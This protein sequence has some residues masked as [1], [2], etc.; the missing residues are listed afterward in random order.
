M[1]G[2]ESWTIKKAEHQ[3][4]DANK[5]W[6]CRRLLRVPW[7]SRISNQSILKEIKP[8]YSLE[9]L[10]LRVKLQYFGHWMWRP[11][12]CESLKVGVDGLLLVVVESLKDKGWWDGLMASLTQCLYFEQAL[13]DSGLQGSLDCCNPQGHKELN[14]TEQLHKNKA[15]G[16]QDHRKIKFKYQRI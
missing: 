5:L 2:C 7:T 8:E 10:M 3:R 14:P 4:I 9:E 13:G 1:Y 15:S 16:G 6:F 11:C 12:C